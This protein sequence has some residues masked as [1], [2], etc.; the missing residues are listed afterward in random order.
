MSEETKTPEA[1]DEPN[2][3]SGAPA[4]LQC[5]FCAYWWDDDNVE[6]EGTCHRHAPVPHFLLQSSLYGPECAALRAAKSDPFLAQWPVTKEDDFCGDF[7]LAP[8]DELEAK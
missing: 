5:A 8:L 3:P 6:G 1:P 4:E 2:E 7:R